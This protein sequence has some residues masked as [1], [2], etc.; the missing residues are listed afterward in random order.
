MGLRETWPGCMDARICFLAPLTPLPTSSRVSKVS[1]ARV[2]I[3]VG[4]E[5]APTADA[6]FL[7]SWICESSC[8]DMQVHVYRF[9]RNWSTGI[10]F[11]LVRI[12]SFSDSVCHTSFQGALAVRGSRCKSLYV[13]RTSLLSR[14]IKSDWSRADAAFGGSARRWASSRA[15]FDIIFAHHMSAAWS[16]PSDPLQDVHAGLLHPL[17]PFPC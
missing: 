14:L 9:I 3:L 16:L 6:A 1:R 4:P 8:I 17:L 5:L 13:L 10:L 12:A 2:T 15:R 7:S 11:A